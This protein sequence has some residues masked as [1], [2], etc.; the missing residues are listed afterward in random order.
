MNTYKHQSLDGLSSTNIVY[1][2][3][4]L[5]AVLSGHD[6][7]EAIMDV[8]RESVDREDNGFRNCKTEREE[9]VSASSVESSTRN[10]SESDPLHQLISEE[11]GTAY[12]V[13][14][15]S[16]YLG[17]NRA[18][19]NGWNPKSYARHEK[20]SRKA[21]ADNGVV[22]G[23]FSMLTDHVKKLDKVRAKLAALE[24][25]QAKRAAKKG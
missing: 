18:W 20:A 15:L 24:A 1:D 16:F 13:D 21:Q 7:A 6:N 8:L 9:G 4:V 23:E 11:S 17:D 2:R 12:I 22:W 5:G 10:S 14:H 3:E 25:K 19:R